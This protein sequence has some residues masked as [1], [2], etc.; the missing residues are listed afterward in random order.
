LVDYAS[1]LNE[2][3][4]HLAACYWVDETLNLTPEKG[5]VA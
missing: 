5:T 2:I 1:R 3:D 4:Q